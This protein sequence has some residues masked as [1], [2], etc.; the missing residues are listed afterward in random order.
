MGGGGLFGGASSSAGLF[1]LQS[2]SAGQGTGLSFSF[3]NSTKDAEAAI[4]TVHGDDKQR[5]GKGP[6]YTWEDAGKLG[7]TLQQLGESEADFGARISAVKDPE[8]LAKLNA[9]GVEINMTV[10]E[11][12]GEDVT[13]LS[14]REIMGRLKAASRP[15][16]VRFSEQVPSVPSSRGGGLVCEAAATS[17]KSQSP[18]ATK[19]SSSGAQAEE[20]V[21]TVIVYV[22]A[23]VE[24]FGISCH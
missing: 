10:A 2:L 19:P 8:L 13:Q 11:V 7:L 1:S 20:A 12:A 5:P 6:S 3:G 21:K 9:N 17:T 14:Y 23:W 4:N 16:T 22:L 18:I 15:L 24:I